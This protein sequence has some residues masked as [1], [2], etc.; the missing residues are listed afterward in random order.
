MKEKTLT[1]KKFY[2]FLFLA[3]ICAGFS[4]PL[5][6]LV[7]NKTKVFYSG[8]EVFAYCNFYILLFLILARKQIIK[9]YNFDLFAFRKNIT[10]I[11]AFAIFLS[12]ISSTLKTV[13][14]AGASFQ[15]TQ[16]DL[17]SYSSLCPFVTVA[18]CHFFIVGQQASKKFLIALT[19]AIFGFFVF[20]KFAFSSNINMYILFYVLVNAVSDFLLKKIS[21]A[22]GVNMALFDNLMFF[23]VSTVIFTVAFFDSQLTTK[24]L[25]MQAFSFDKLFS[26]Y[27]LLGLVFVALL[28][29]FAHVFK[30]LA[31]KI[32]HVVGLL[33][34]GTVSK[35]LVS[36]ITTYVEKGITPNLYQITG[37]C[38]MACGLIYLGLGKNAN[39]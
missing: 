18:L 28:S 34:F 35:N 32:T 21:S 31:Y 9:K 29:F 17:K 4:Y 13:L 26:I 16:L 22:R 20:N 19:V 6:N 15:I 7:S 24:Y 23:F 37:L 8:A 38:I 39:K 2:L 25:Q 36:I 27:A 30:M 33:V 12:V 3:D 10:P 5:A 1:N 14:L 11:F